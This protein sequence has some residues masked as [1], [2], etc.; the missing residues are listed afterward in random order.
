MKKFKFSPNETGISTVHEVNKILVSKGQ[1]KVG[2][3]S[4]GGKWQTNI[5]AFNASDGY[6]PPA[7]IYTRQRMASSLEV[8]G[9]C[10]KNGWTNKAI[11]VQWLYH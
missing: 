11:F 4:L 6:I 9:L 5:Y 1:K 8:N 3:V 2:V 10:L 7:F